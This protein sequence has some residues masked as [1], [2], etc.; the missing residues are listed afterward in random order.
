MFHPRLTD[1]R[2]QVGDQAVVA[3]ITL[4][5]TSTTV[6]TTQAAMESTSKPTVEV[7]EIRWKDILISET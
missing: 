1:K 6:T 2:N 7:K 4:V 3:T 5:A